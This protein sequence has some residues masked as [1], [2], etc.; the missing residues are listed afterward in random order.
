MYNSKIFMFMNP[1]QFNEIS[2]L[3]HYTTL[4]GIFADKW[5]QYLLDKLPKHFFLPLNL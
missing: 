1:N 2:L 5:S 3:Y 4:D